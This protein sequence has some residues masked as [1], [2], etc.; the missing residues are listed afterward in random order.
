MHTH[1]WEDMRTVCLYLCLF[2]VCIYSVPYLSLDDKT[3]V[4]NAD[5]ELKSSNGYKV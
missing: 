2:Y 4:S 5:P 3:L 1:R